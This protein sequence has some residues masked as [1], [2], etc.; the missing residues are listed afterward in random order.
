MTGTECHPSSARPYHDS[1]QHRRVGSTPCGRGSSRP[2]QTG[3]AVG[4]ASNG[5][6]WAGCRVAGCLSKAR[7]GVWRGGGERARP[8]QPCHTHQTALCVANCVALPVREQRWHAIVCAGSLA[9]IK[10]IAPVPVALSVEARRVAVAVTDPRSMAIGLRSHH[11]ERTSS[12]ER[13]LGGPQGQ[14]ADLATCRAC[15]AILPIFKA[16]RI[17]ALRIA[18]AIAKRVPLAAWCAEHGIVLGSHEI[19]RRLGYGEHGDGEVCVGHTREA[20]RSWQQQRIAPHRTY[21]RSRNRERRGGCCMPRHCPPPR[22]TGSC[23]GQSRR[24]E[25]HCPPA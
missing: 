14:R 3:S 25:P 11:E 15:R 18:Y 22:R 13:V 2:G 1:L 6:V 5:V 8:R 7:P 21:Q 9:L 24:H 16:P 17:V 10:A 4:G 20:Q 12:S 19:Q 23:T